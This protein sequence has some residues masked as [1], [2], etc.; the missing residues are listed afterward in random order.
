MLPCLAFVGRWISVPK[1]REL[2]K[3]IK[4]KRWQ[5]RI[6]RKA[7]ELDSSNLHAVDMLKKLQWLPAP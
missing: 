2:I 1:V 4:P 3:R 5:S 6:Y 7:V